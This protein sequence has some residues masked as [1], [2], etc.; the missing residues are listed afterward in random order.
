[1]HSSLDL[2]KVVASINYMATSFFNMINNIFWIENKIF[3]SSLSFIFSYSSKFEL[4]FT[5]D[6]NQ[7]IV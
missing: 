5:F 3:T 7:K 6:I 1:M 4:L 2:T